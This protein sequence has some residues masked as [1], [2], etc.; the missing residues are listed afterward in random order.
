M[1]K[2]ER[3]MGYL[4]LAPYLTPEQFEFRESV[5]RVLT[6][7]ATPDYLRLHDEEKRFPKELVELIGSRACSPIRCPGSAVA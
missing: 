7:H 6:Q 4:D 2:L 3:L 1:E 5:S